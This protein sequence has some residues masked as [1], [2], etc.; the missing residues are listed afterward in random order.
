MRRYWGR[1][2][3]AIDRTMIEGDNLGTAYSKDQKSLNFYE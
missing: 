3:E 2:R 1:G